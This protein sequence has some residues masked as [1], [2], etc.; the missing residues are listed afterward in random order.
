[1]GKVTEKFRLDNKVAVITGAGM[2]M[3]RL[4]A[5]K[6]SRAGAML[7]LVDVNRQALE[8]TASVLLDPQYVIDRI[9]DAM[10]KD[11]LY[12]YLPWW[13]RFIPILF[14]ILPAPA[15]DWLLFKTGVGRTMEH[16]TGHGGNKPSD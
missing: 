16:W 12:V 13:L 7:V 14:Y 15:G 2:G 1:M 8:Q 10:L 4:F 11:K 3:G 9:F 5:L 6:F